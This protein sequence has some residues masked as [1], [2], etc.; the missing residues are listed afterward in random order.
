MTP[1]QPSAAPSRR[2][3]LKASAASMTSAAILS[4]L[5]TNFAYA[6]APNKIKVGQRLVIP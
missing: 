6:Q 3:V 5:G 4:A 2:S 1:N